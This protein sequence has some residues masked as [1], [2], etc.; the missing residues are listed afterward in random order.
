MISRSRLALDG[1]WQFFYDKNDSISVKDRYAD[2]AD[3]NADDADFYQLW[4]VVDDNPLYDEREW[5]PIS[6]PGPWQAQFEDLRL[7]AGTGWY[8]RTF[9]T[10]E[11]WRDGSDGS[12]VLHFGAVDYLARVWLNGT[13]VGEHEGG[14]LPFEFEVGELLAAEGE[15]L[16]VVRVFDPPADGND[17][18]VQFAEIPHGKQS[19]YGQLSGIWQ[20]V[21]MEARPLTHIERVKITPDAKT[22]D[23]V[24]E[25]AANRPLAARDVVYVTIV[26]MNGETVAGTSVAEASGGAA[27]LKLHVSDPQLWDVDRPYLYEARVVLEGE[28]GRDEV[29]ESF[30]WRTIE[31]RE[32][33]LWLN[34]RPLY[35]RGALDQDYYPDLIY[36]PPSLEYIEAQFRQARAMGLN[37]LRVHIKVADPR[38]Y[39]A[40]DRVGLLIWT[41]LP[42]WKALTETADAHARETIAG[43]VARDWNHPSI[44]IWTII[45]ESWGVD[46][47]KNPAHRAW[48]AEMFEWVKGL[49]PTRLV[50][51]NSP[52]FHNVHVQSDID[53]FH[54]YAAMPD[55]MARWER[56]VRDFAGR[57]SWLYGPEP[58]YQANREKGAPLVVSEFGN[59]GLPDIGPLV[60]HYG[61]G[62]PWWFATG[63]NWSGGDVHPQG[64]AERFEQLHLDKVFGD[65]AGLARASQWAQFEA[66]KYEIETMRLH[67]AIQGYVITEF[68]D[69]HWE[70][71]GLL[72]MLRRPKVYY[73]RLAELNADTV[74]IPRTERLACWGGETIAIRLHVA[75]AGATAIENVFM[76]VELPSGMSVVTEPASFTVQAAEVMELAPLRISLPA[77]NVPESFELHFS[78]HDLQGNVLARNRL[79]LSLF[80]AAD[81]PLPVVACTDAALAEKLKG[82]G[83][84]VLETA[85]PDVPLVLTTLDEQ[86]LGFVEAGG[87]VLFLAEGAEALQTA[88]P[89]LELQARRGTPWAGDWASSFAWYRRD[90]WGKQVPG[91]GRLDFSFAPIVPET[92]ISSTRVEDFADD[93]LAG[94]FVGWLRRPVGL[95]QRMGIGRGTLLVSTLRLGGLVDDDPS[96]AMLLLE[97]LRLLT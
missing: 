32:G 75:H 23:V 49:D 29:S 54:Y 58:E 47:E 26:D 72:D 22:G 8:R 86:G 30:G 65:Y 4:G 24:V 77:V 94:L 35:L 95:V 79:G 70:C 67:P 3:E 11:A 85:S 76:C 33:R 59:W 17:G 5:R 31:A 92:V 13:F 16:L 60:A 83:Y 27:E 68:T 44:V 73:Q 2:D 87:R 48:L 20:P 46:L 12:V 38:Y 91:D 10:P 50:V 1:E 43:M 37:C 66:L 57:P 40:A 18:A 84:R 89:G 55:G 71:N 81:A 78:V 69:L 21:W 56:W 42:N 61:G 28:G 88:V 64:A 34:G 80:P 15:N 52:C 36:T 90:L 96:A 82:A 6:V 51:D 53:D 63:H 41:E 19:W 93:V 25:V 74:I 45:N 14:Y 9:Q 7:A 39:E 62:E 97:H